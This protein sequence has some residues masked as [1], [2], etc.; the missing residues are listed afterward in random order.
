MYDKTTSHQHCTLILAL[1]RQQ[2]SPS[3]VHH[4]HNLYTLFPSHGQGVIIIV[5]QPGP[6]DPA[7][8]TLADLFRK[9]VKVPPTP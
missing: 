7:D 9:Q 6:T 5:H 8:K 1:M 3:Y 2:H 4:I